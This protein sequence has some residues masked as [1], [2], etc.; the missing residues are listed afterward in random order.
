[1]DMYLHVRVLFSIVLGLGISRLLSGV[2]RI[3]QHPKEYKVYWVHLLW[4]LFLFL[5]LIHFWWWEYR[6]QG[7]QQ[8][9]FPLYFFIAMYA[10]L[11]FLLCVLFFPEEMADYEGFK[12]YFYSRRRWIFSLMTVL[13]V[14]D[15]ADTL[16]KGSAYLQTLGPIYY[17]R[18]ALCILLSAAAIKIAN[19]RFHAAFAVFATGYEILLILKDYMTVG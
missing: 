19:Q 18:I 7:V 2:A 9:T 1:M 10:I 6:L 14:A 4:A 3:V 15:F 16:I 11:L 5:Y 12:D 13:F 17:L 8:W